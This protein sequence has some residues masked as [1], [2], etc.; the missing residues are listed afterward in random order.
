MR[1]LYFCKKPFTFNR[2][3]LTQSFTFQ[4]SKQPPRLNNHESRDV[5]PLRACFMQDYRRTDGRASPILSPM[6]QDWRRMRVCAKCFLLSVY[7]NVLNCF[8]NPRALKRNDHD[9]RTFCNSLNFKC[10]NLQ[11]K[12]RVFYSLHENR[13]YLQVRIK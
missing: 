7:L 4:L 10:K 9:S 12:Q 3:C 6:H 8:F 5:F 13:L 1:Q 2:H 11:H